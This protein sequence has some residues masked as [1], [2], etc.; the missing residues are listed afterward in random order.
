MLIQHR[1]S[2][3]CFR[4][5]RH[6]L[7]PRSDLAEQLGFIAGKMP[8]HHEPAEGEQGM[9]SNLQE[10]AKMRSRV[11]DDFWLMSIVG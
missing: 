3:R 4:R 8:L 10:L 11:S 7:R 9:E 6:L 1:R 2:V 5:P